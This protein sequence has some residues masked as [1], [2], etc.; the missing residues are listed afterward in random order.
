MPPPPEGATLSD[1]GCY[2]WDGNQWQ[3]VDD[4]TQAATGSTQSASGNGQQ[5]QTQQGQDQG[6][7]KVEFQGT[8]YVTGTT[9]HWEGANKGNA[10]VMPGHCTDSVTLYRGANRDEM[11]LQQPFDGASDLMP[12]ASYGQNFELGTLDDGPYSVH[13]WLG[14]NVISNPGHD[15]HD[16]LDQGTLVFTMTGG[17]AESDGQSWTLADP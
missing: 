17:A 12:G 6:Y 10:I 9:L 14:S 15:T 7:V 2:W 11:V 4:S 16:A 1:D 5:G 8:P 13:I 3:L